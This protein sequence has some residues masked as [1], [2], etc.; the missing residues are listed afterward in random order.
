[1]SRRNSWSSVLYLEVKNCID[2]LQFYFFNLTPLVPDFDF[3][4]DLVCKNQSG[5]QKG[6]KNIPLK[7][8]F[9]V[10][11]FCNIDNDVDVAM[12]II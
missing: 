1:M 11:L 2:R 5:S 12:R 9:A 6:F 7:L 10:C 4:F 8:F 3:I